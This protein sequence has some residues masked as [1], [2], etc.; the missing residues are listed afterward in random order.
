MP[1][2]ARV[3]GVDVRVQ[4]RAVQSNSGFRCRL[5]SIS[6]SDADL[7]GL[8]WLMLAQDVD[9]VS[10]ATSFTVV[11]QR[12]TRTRAIKESGPTAAVCGPH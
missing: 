5:I 4:Q 3:A 9:T 10:T 11:A 6:L 2:V 1:G 7:T 8:R 12:K